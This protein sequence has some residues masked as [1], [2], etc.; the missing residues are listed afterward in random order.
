MK[1]KPEIILVRKKWWEVYGILLFTALIIMKLKF[2]IEQ[3]EKFADCIRFVA[4][5]KEF[6]HEFSISVK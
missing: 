5:E 1:S 4:L 6:S 2:A 3:V